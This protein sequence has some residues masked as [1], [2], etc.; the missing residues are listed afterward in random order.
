MIFDE[1]PSLEARWRPELTSRGTFSILSSCLITLGLCIWTAVH[2]NIPDHDSTPKHS[3]WDP[4]SWVSQQQRRR[5]GW[6]VLGML[7]PEMVRQYDSFAPEE[8]S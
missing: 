6:L 1:P 8:G 2:L 7:A 4:R 5:L 3:Q